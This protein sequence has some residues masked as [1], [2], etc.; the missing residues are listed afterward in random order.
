MKGNADSRGVRED[1]SGPSQFET[2]VVG[3]VWTSRCH[4][5]HGI[6]PASSWVVTP[7]LI[8]RGLPFHGRGSRRAFTAAWAGEP[9]R[10]SP[11]G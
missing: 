6:A 8:A 7:T 1:L 5:G 4:V 9:P 2:R 11:A 3:D 10:P